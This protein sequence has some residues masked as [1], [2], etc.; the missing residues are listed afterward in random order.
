MPIAVVDL[1]RQVAD[2]RGAFR[3]IFAVAKNNAEVSASTQNLPEGVRDPIILRLFS[4]SI[5]SH[6]K[7]PAAISCWLEC[8]NIEGQILFA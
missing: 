1:L 3:R 2:E 7:T 4:S 6:R 5:D 8:N